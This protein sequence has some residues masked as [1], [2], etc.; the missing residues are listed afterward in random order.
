[1]ISKIK[2]GELVRAHIHYSD[3]IYLLLSKKNILMFFIYRDPRDIAI[4]EAYYLYS[5]NKFHSAHKYFKSKKTHNER[6]RLS[7]EGINSNK[8]DFKNIGE[9]IDPYVNW[10]IK[11]L[12]NVLAI[13]FEEMKNN[14]DKVISSMYYFFSKKD[15]FKNKNIS[16]DNFSKEVKKSINPKKS[17]TFRKGKAKKWKAEFDNDLLELFE[18]NA[19]EVIKKLGYK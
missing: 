11:K 4:S 9:R 14:I 18:K 16:L 1:M 2:N 17:H 13:S 5:M 12:D 8:I 10:K 6:L 7:I 3:S 19:N 15:F